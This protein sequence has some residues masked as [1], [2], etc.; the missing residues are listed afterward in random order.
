[1]PAMLLLNKAQRTL[2]AEKLSEIG[3]LAAAALIFGQFLSERLFS[4]AIAFL[5]LIIWVVLMGCAMAT[6]RRIES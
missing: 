5:G 1:M 3:N 6:A 2:L 4:S